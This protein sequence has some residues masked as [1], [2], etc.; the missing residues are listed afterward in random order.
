MLSSFEVS[1]KHN[2]YTVLALESRR[3]KMNIRVNN[4]EKLN[5]IF[6]NKFLEI[7]SIANKKN[8]EFF[9]HKEPSLSK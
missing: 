5:D 1:R 2:A 8:R 6:G 9:G 7:T 4:I 3:R